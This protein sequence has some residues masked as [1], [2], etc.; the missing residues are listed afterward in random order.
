MQCIS[1]AS[2]EGTS[3][4]SRFYKQVAPTV[5]L[6]ARSPTSL[7]LLCR[8]LQVALKH[9]VSFVEF[10]KWLLSITSELT[11]CGDYQGL[12][13]LAVKSNRIR[14]GRIDQRRKFLGRSDPET[15]VP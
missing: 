7:R 4:A 2:R 6:S 8:V 5:L 1:L 11:E 10:C 3:E 9:F 14:Q 15:E 12:R 13:R